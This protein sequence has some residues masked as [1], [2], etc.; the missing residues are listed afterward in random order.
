MRAWKVG[1]AEN[2]GI[3]LIELEIPDDAKKLEYGSNILNKSGKCDFADV[4]SITSMDSTYGMHK[5]EKAYS[6]YDFNF[7]YKVG[8]RVY[9][10]RFVECS[11]D[12][13]TPG[14]HYFHYKS[15][16]AAYAWTGWF[17]IRQHAFWAYIQTELIEKYKG[18]VSD[19][20]IYI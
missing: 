3:A 1:F 11:F 12:E 9:A 14:I 6:A 19:I 13:C 20:P 5:V 16:A 10:D 7:I 4:I 18:K 2:G 17:R 15:A 8:T